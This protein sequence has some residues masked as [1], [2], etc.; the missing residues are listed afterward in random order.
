MA[1]YLTLCWFIADRPHGWRKIWS[2]PS[3]SA[4]WRAQRRA[5]DLLTEPITDYVSA[6]PLAA[7]RVGLR[8]VR[9]GGALRGNITASPGP[10]RRKAWGESAGVFRTVELLLVGGRRVLL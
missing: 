6:V 3:L 8:S 5:E 10:S 7:T 2:S 1:R 4:T 9:T